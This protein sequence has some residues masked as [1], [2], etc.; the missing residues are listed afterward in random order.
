LYTGA[1]YTM[2]TV[3]D[4]TPS[5]LLQL[6]PDVVGLHVPPAAE[7]PSATTAAGGNLQ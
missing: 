7:P 6:Q 3:N 1:V 2:L 5:Q 4:N